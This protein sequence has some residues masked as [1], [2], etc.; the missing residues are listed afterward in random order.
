MFDIFGPIQEADYWQA[1]QRIIA[2]GLPE[3]VRVTYKGEIANAVVPAT[4]AGYDLFFLPTR[5]ENFGHAIFDALEAGVPALI[6]DQTPFCDLE[7]H[8]AGWTLPLDEPERFVAAI[9]AVH[10][11]APDEFNRMRG[12]ARF[13][14]ERTIEDSDAVA[15]N[16]AMLSTALSSTSRAR[17]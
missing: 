17:Q 14:A 15:Q 3:N 11:M 16:I 13:L 9:D 10:R 2:K 6:S 8:G 12:A 5:G 1:C 7:R 4:L